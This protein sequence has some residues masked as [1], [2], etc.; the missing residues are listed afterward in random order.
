MTEVGVWSTNYLVNPYLLQKCLTLSS[1]EHNFLWQTAL[2][3]YQWCSM[4][5]QTK[6]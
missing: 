2:W 4:W 6:P 3:W 5:C 1:H